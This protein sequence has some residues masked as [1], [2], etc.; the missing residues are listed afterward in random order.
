VDH[1]GSVTVERGRPA[2]AAFIVRLPLEA[3]P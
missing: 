3:E 2:G 1:G